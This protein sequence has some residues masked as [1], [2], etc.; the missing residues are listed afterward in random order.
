MRDGFPKLLGGV[1][2]VAF[3]AIAAGTVLFL[4]WL[5]L[6]FAWDKASRPMGA[7]RRAFASGWVRL[8]VVL[9]P[10]WALWRAKDI[11]SDGTWLVNADDADWLLTGA[12]LPLVAFL[13]GWWVERGFARTGA[14][15]LPPPK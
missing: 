6:V 9:W 12:L 10:A 7:L 1:V 3:L 14:A 15:L 8:F 13:L 2:L 5:L 11:D 4:A